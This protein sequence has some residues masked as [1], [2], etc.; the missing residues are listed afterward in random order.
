MSHPVAPATGSGRIRTPLP[1]PTA[2][3]PS[4]A[5]AAAARPTCAGPPTP[6]ATSGPG[7]STRCPTGRRC[8]TP[9]RR[10]RPTSGAGCRS[11]WSSSRRPPPLPAPPCTGPAT[12]P[13]R[14]GSSPTWSGPPGADEVVKV[15]SMATQEIGLNEA[16]EAAGIA[17]YETDLAELIVQLADDTPSHIL[18]PAIH[19]N[20]T[21]DP[22]HLRQRGCPTRRAD[23]TDEPAGARRGGPRRTCGDVPVRPGRGLRRQ[24]RRR[25]HRHARGASS[26][27][28]TAGCA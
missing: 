15:K 7:S 6:S 18:V 3:R 21:A 26:P 27:R 19:Y 1:F 11:C 25:R 12:R 17:A 14:A 22:G 23:L 2:A 16:L 28:A 20:R 5:D 9:A 13:R 10:S 24:L 8:A 4:V